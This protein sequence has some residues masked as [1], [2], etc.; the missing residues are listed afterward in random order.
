MLNDL[1][2]N[3][4]LGANSDL[5]HENTVAEGSNLLGIVFDWIDV[6]LV[7]HFDSHQRW[8][9]PSHSL[10]TRHGH[11]QHTGA[12]EADSIISNSQTLTRNQRLS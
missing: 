4:K 7:Q 10:S 9:F 5:F 8:S 1:L 3:C 12:H 2:L 11:G 6:I